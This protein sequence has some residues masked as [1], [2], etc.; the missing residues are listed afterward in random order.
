[1]FY[2]LA[3]LLGLVVLGGLFGAWQT[4]EDRGTPYTLIGSKV[5]SDTEVE[6]TFEVPVSPGGTVHCDVRAR[7]RAGTEVGHDRVQVGPQRTSPVRVVHVVTTSA[8][9][10]TGE[11]TGCSA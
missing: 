2:L 11:V 5:L 10:A 9:A 3:G 4:F 1:V 6:V 8:R 7:D